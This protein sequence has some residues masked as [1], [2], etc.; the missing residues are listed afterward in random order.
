MNNP[1]NKEIAQITRNTI[2][3]YPTPTPNELMANF[4]FEKGS[5]FAVSKFSLNRSVNSC[6]NIKIIEIKNK[7]G[8]IVVN[9]QTT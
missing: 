4:T 2:L 3:T 6:V 1:K 7:V 5:N 9:V 8:I